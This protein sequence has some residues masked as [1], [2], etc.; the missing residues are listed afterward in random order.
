VADETGERRRLDPLA[1]HVTDDDAPSLVVDAEGVVE[2]AAHE[3]GVLRRPVPG[4]QHRSRWRHQPLRE[5]AALQRLC[6]VALLAVLA[7]VVLGQRERFCLRALEAKQER[8]DGDGPQRPAEQHDPPEVGHQLSAEPPDRRRHEQDVLVAE[9]DRR[10]GAAPA[11]GQLPQAR[12]EQLGRVLARAEVEGVVEVRERLVGAPADVGV[13]VQL[14]LGV[15]DVLRWVGVPHRIPEGAVREHVDDDEGMGVRPRQET[16]ARGLTREPWG[17]ADGCQ[18]LAG[19]GPVEH[20]A[21]IAALLGDQRRGQPGEGR[22]IAGGRLGSL[23]DAVERC[24]DLGDRHGQHGSRLVGLL[25]QEVLLVLVGQHL[26]HHRQRA[27]PQHADEQDQHR[28]A[29]P[30]HPAGRRHDVIG[31]VDHGRCSATSCTE[32]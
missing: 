30:P 7:R 29:R 2:V 5:Q 28:Q 17:G 23:H 22:R 19:R 8:G 16:V 14:P 26:A 13:G 25:L 27:E 12:A 21:A 11:D 18:R 3:A 31:A 10:V 9:R 1:A 6:D 32:P 4:R 20:H 15:H 24:L